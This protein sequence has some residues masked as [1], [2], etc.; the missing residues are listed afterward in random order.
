MRY[1][2]LVM[3]NDQGAVAGAVAAAKLNLRVGLVVSDAGWQTGGAERLAWGFWREVVAEALAEWSETSA[4]GADGR[5]TGASLET[6]FQRFRR[7][8]TLTLEHEA[9]FQQLELE[10]FGIDVLVGQ[11]EFTSPHEIVLRTGQGVRHVT[12]ER[13]LLAT[14]ARSG[15]P[16][17]FGVNGRNILDVTDLPKL[18]VVPRSVIV[19]GGGQ[20]GLESARYLARFGAQVTI[21]DGS[22]PLPDGR[23][24][25]AD[26]LRELAEECRRLGV[27]WELGAD[28]LALEPMADG[29]VGLQLETGRRI[30]GEVV[31]CATGWVGNTAG[32]NLPAAGISPDDR[33][34]IWCDADGQTWARHIS[35]TGAVV[36]HPAAA[37]YRAGE[38][39]RVVCQALRSLIDSRSL[40]AG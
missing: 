36:G 5:S 13:F 37:R 8:V 17:K 38:G 16:A 26:G 11:P 12:A 24:R 21:V 1:D 34:R 31:V 10:H 28:V 7:Q 25:S 6:E 3:G 4:T 14:G 35:A 15:V 27:R 39:T 20:S 30:C 23:G 22:Q 33:G 29:Q 18:S 40:V 9:E 19:V 2:L 32:L